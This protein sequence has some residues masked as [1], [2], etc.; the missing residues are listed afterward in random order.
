MIKILQRCVLIPLFLWHV[1]LKVIKNFFSIWCIVALIV[2]WCLDW[3]S[4]SFDLPW[5]AIWMYAILLSQTIHGI[6][7]TIPDLPL[8]LSVFIRIML[9][10]G[11]IM[12]LL[13]SEEFIRA[14][15][16][17]KF[18][19]YF[20]PSIE[21]IDQMLSALEAKKIMEAEIDELAKKVERNLALLKSMEEKQ[22]E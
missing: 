13:Y 22:D 5:Y 18:D 21:E 1:T 4:F 11:T 17:E 16:P 6:F 15:Y 10:G 12:E 19:E 8:F 20:G 14:F 2:L 7:I 3:P 9:L